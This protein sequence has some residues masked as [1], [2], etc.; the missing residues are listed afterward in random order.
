ML[1]LQHRRTTVH[2]A[3]DEE[4]VDADWGSWKAYIGRGLRA[5]RRVLAAYRSA[6]EAPGT[7]LHLLVCLSS[8]SEDRDR[9]RVAPVQYE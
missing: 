1:G 9:A 5:K 6:W 8:F 2:E 4:L 3:D 7:L